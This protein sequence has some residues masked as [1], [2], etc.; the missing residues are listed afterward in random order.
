MEDS[1]DAD[2]T[3]PNKL[4]KT[5]TRLFMAQDVEGSM[6]T[7]TTVGLASGGFSTRTAKPD[8]GPEKPASADLV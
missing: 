3:S 4:I 5:V 1:R 7:A 6:G 8:A 2:Q